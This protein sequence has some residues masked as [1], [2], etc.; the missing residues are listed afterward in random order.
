ME[1]QKQARRRRHIFPVVIEVIRTETGLVLEI[2][3]SAQAVTE[4]ILCVRGVPSTVACF[5][6]YYVLKKV[7]WVL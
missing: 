2:C 5:E 3:D 6:E 4:K 1:A 7:M